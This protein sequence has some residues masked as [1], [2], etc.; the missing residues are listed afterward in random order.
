MEGI[1]RL[2][3]FEAIQKMQEIFSRS[4]PAI[5]AVSLIAAV[6]THFLFVSRDREERASRSFFQIVR[7]V[8][9]FRSM[10]A[11]SAIRIFYLAAAIASLICG[12]ICMI[13]IS[14]FPGLIA[15]VLVEILL[16]LA[17]EALVVVFSIHEQLVSLNE[18]GAAA[19]EDENWA[20]EAW[21]EPEKDSPNP[22]ASAV[23]GDATAADRPI[24]KT[25]SSSDD[26]APGGATTLKEQEPSSDPTVMRIRHLLDL[27]SENAVHRTPDRRTRAATAQNVA[28]GSTEAAAKSSVG[29]APA[30]CAGDKEVSRGSA[31]LRIPADE[32]LGEVDGLDLSIHGKRKDDLSRA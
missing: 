29:S 32:E 30:G 7:D 26:R 14:F 2:G 15:L 8:L 18:R 23:A 4:L 16:R 27:H 3:I 13:S 28:G 6:W 10:L 1:F 21:D 20:E 9:R 24:G 17:C 22:V 25:R 11:T 12:V 31:S 19:G 5:L